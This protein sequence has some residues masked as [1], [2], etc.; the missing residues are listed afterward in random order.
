MTAGLFLSSPSPTRLSTN[1][2]AGMRFA[3]AIVRTLGMRRQIRVPWLIEDFGFLAPKP[4]FALRCQ[5]ASEE[6]S[7]VSCKYTN[8]ELIS[9]CSDA[10]CSAFTR[11][12]HVEH[13]DAMIL[14]PGCDPSRVTSRQI[15][16]QTGLFVLAR[17]AV[18]QQGAAHHAFSVENQRSVGVDYVLLR[19]HLVIG[20]VGLVQ[21]VTRGDRSIF[22]P[23]APRA[24]ASMGDSKVNGRIQ[25]PAVHTRLAAGHDAFQEGKVRSGHARYGSRARIQEGIRLQRDETKSQQSQTPRVASPRSVLGQSRGYIR[26]NSGRGGVSMTIPA[27]SRSGLLTFSRL[28]SYNA[29]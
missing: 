20:G 29:L 6:L 10:G 3:A 4:P 27:S 8:Y 17:E 14:Q 21:L 11:S 18:R 12:S 16:L 5:R 22:R 25:R 9:L 23:P 26:R 13:S 1:C 24:P 7:I 19:P 28:C 15:E 2:V